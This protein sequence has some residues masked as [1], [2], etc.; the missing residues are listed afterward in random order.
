[1][2]DFSYCMPT[3]IVLQSGGLEKL[4]ELIPKVRSVTVVTGRSSARR[5]GLCDRLEN[6]LRETGVETV[7]FASASP[8]PPVSEVETA[9]RLAS[10][11]ASELMIGLGGGSA[12]DTA[13]AAAVV[14]TNDRPLMELFPIHRFDNAPLPLVCIPTT[15]G[16]GSETTQYAIINNDE[17]TDKLNLN[18]PRT[19]PILALLDP[20][21]SLTMPQDITA[22]TG[23]DALSHA[24]EG[25]LSSRSQP[26]GDC[27]A[28][29]SIRAVKKY[30]PGAVR[31]GQD[32]EARAGM[33]Y[34]A[35]VAGMVIAQAGTIMLHAMGYYLTLRYGVPHGRAN[36]ALL[37]HCLRL[38]E[39][40][41]Q[42]K[43]P[44]V[45]S[46]FGAE[47]GG[48]QAIKDFV[49]SLAVSTNLREYGVEE[50]D[51]DAFRDYVMERKNV[52]R[53]PGTVTA[54]H[55]QRLLNEAMD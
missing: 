34:A 52:P 25:Y 8:N 32:V 3:R 44:A 14:A 46:I 23:L 16:T 40:A 20:E 36:G 51:L 45:Y 33:L 7:S 55:V 37:S 11:S 48:H 39:G 18:S 17:G 30:L 41:S 35:T 31:D 10:E 1:M 28:L 5:S 6:I 21:L 54:E 42:G 9:A 19:F 4:G 12:M 47:R 15:A 38:I 43:L 26:L 13:K 24:I 49:E 2:N 50:N 29:E 27:L 53:T 22:D